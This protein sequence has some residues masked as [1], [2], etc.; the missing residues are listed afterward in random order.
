[1]PHT[2]MRNFLAVRAGSGVAPF[3]LE[4]PATFL[5]IGMASA[6]GSQTV[7]APIANS[8]RGDLIAVRVIAPSA[9]HSVAVQSPPGSTIDTFAPSSGNTRSYIF[10]GLRYVPF[11]ASVG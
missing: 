10:N 3:V 6:S 7:H 1:M 8:Q 11:G 4:N 9:V 2:H 5:T